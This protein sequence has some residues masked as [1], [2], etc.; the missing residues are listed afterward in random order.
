[1]IA[2]AEFVLKFIAG[3]V[4]GSF[5]LAAIWCITFT[6]VKALSRMD[7]RE[8]EREDEGKGRKR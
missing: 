8:D 1:M 4:L 6:T 7:E 5:L 2:A 3:W